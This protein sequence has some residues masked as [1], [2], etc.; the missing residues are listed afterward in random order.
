MPDQPTGPDLAG[1]IGRPPEEVVSFFEEK[2]YE[3]SF[4]WQDVWQDAHKKAFTVAGVTKMDALESIRGEV[5]KA[6]AEGTT[7]REFKK[8]L[9]PKLREQ[10]FW[11]EREVVDEETGEVRTTDLSQPWRLRTIYRTNL[12]T[13]YMKGRWESQ[14]AARDR[15]PYLRYDAQIDSRTTARCRE[16]NNLVL[17]ADDPFWRRNYPPN[18]W[19]CRSA[20]QSLSERQ[21]ERRDL[22]VESSSES[23]LDDIATDEWAYNPGEEDFEADLSEHNDRIA[24][25]Y[26]DAQE[27]YE[28]PSR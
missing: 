8:N 25:D 14:Q 26:Q 27:E 4:R 22:D 9:E 18:H 3:F 12:Q 5:E 13:S 28:P 24:S 23:E 16:R 20:T 17:R 21:V 10:G 15:R 11:G 1:L 19:G 7:L 2:G 6:L